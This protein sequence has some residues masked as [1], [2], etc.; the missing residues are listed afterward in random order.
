MNNKNK[1]AYLSHGD[2]AIYVTLHFRFRCM[3][4]DGDG[5]LSMY[6][7]EYFYEEQLQRIEKFGIGPLPFKASLCQVFV[8][9]LTYNAT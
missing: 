7:I 5:Y 9:L 8:S 4:L 1:A 2:N 6:E 3:D